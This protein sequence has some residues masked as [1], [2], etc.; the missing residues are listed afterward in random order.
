MRC[1]ALP[2]CVAPG[3]NTR[4][5]LGYAT[6]MSYQPNFQKEVLSCLYKVYHP[7][8]VCATW[9]ATTPTALPPSAIASRSTNGE[10]INEWVCSRTDCC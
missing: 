10:R 2:K 5:P 8:P 9:R 6:P 3:I 1:D 4:A 7:K